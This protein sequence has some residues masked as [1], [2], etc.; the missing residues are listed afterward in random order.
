MVAG[1]AGLGCQ[2]SCVNSWSPREADRGMDHSQLRSPVQ[3]LPPPAATPGMRRDMVTKIRR[4]P[5]PVPPSP[6][7]AD[8]AYSLASMVTVMRFGD[9]SFA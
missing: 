7:Q 8:P 3:T 9:P 5:V 1:A 2:A 6:W 4:A